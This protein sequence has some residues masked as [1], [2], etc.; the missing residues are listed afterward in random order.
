M[1]RR[2]VLAVIALLVTA[3]ALSY[4]Y[5]YLYDNTI[6]DIITPPSGRYAYAY[7]LTSEIYACCAI[8]S[9]TRLLKHSTDPNIDILI[10][11]KT[12]DK[13]SLS[14]HLG[15]LEALDKR[16]K[17]SPIDRHLSTPFLKILFNG[18]YT[19]CMTKLEI[20]SQTQYDRIVYMDADGYPMQNLDH[21]FSLPKAE[22]A[23]PIAWWI[24][25]R[26]GYFSSAFAVVTPSLSTYTRLA[27][28]IKGT[29]NGTG[30]EIG[31]GGEGMHADMEFLNEEYNL[32]F[33][34]C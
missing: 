5:Y 20:F 30:K 10:L 18:L 28:K 19:N 11:Y 16:V 7:Y 24:Q 14:P 26:P 15:T 3:V 1:F 27:D 25:D 4:Y 21:L 23:A 29:A 33:V 31:A 17:L 6:N 12:T 32:F 9:A 2:F 22:L 13:L 34:I 8:I